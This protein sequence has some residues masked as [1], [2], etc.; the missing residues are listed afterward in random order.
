MVGTRPP[1]TR[2]IK[3]YKPHHKARLG[4]KP[5]ITGAWQTSGRNDI[6]DFEEVV[7]LDLSYIQHDNFKNYCKYII[8][9]ITSVFKKTGK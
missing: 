6:T 1:I 3:E 4:E 9:T 5:G 2:E 7:K 8:K